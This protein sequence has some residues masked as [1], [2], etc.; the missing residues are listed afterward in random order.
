MFIARSKVQ[1]FTILTFFCLVFVVSCTSKQQEVMKE[2][3]Y[4]VVLESYFDEIV[5]EEL[6]HDVDSRIHAMYLDLE[7]GSNIENENSDL[8]YLLYCGYSGCGPIVERTECTL[9]TTQYESKPSLSICEKQLENADSTR[10]LA[11]LSV[12][13]QYVCFETCEGNIG[14]IRYDDDFRYNLS[15][16]EIQ[17]TYFLWED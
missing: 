16:G 7:T 8:F 17:L 3:E 6:L 15:E 4:T 5:A 14:W 12:P 9:A 2:V 11:I 1:E 10:I 13:N